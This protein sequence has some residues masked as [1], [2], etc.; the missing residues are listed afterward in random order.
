MDG[1]VNIELKAR[2]NVVVT[3]DDQ[4]LEADWLDYYQDKNR[5]RAG[6]HFR[7]TRER[8]VITGTTLDYNLADY[9]GQGEKP[10][11]EMHQTPKERPAYLPAADKTPVTTVHGDG[12]QVEF[13]GKNLYR[14]Y[15]SRVNTCEVGDDSW[16]I[17]SSTLDLDYNRQIGVARNAR[18]EFRGV[19]IMY[20][21]GWISR[22][23]GDAS[24]AYSR[25]Y[26]RAVAMAA[27]WPFPITG[28]WRPTTMPPSRRT[29]TPGT[30]PCWEP[31]S[32]IWNRTTAARSSPNSYRT[33][34]QPAARA[35]PGMPRTAKPRRRA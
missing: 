11:F 26:S 12:E 18:L 19:P 9:T 1:Q 33:T 24:R 14:L 13:Q 2:G 31:S 7:L 23:T 25:R 4:R 16:Y 27:S 34:A 15:R 28:I 3:R 21:P 20:T 6:D 29:T 35:M 5:A 30:A 22:W 10:V 32:A 17:R 8:D